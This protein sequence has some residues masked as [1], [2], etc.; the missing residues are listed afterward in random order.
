MW[1]CKDN[2]LFFIYEIYIKEL[3]VKVK[4][5]FLRRLLEII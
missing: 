4:M 5:W 2:L 1:F 3:Y